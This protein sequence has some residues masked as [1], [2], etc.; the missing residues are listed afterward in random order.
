MPTRLPY[1]VSFIKPGV[2]S[3]IYTFTSGDTTPDVSLGTVFFTATSAVT[4]TNFDGGERGKIIIVTSESNG[5]TTLQNSAGGINLFATIAAISSGGTRPLTYSSS[6]NY[7]MQN[8]DTLMFIHNGTD[9][10]QI[11]PSVRVN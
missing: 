5:V 6:G 4:I 10:S 11:S 7:L 8:K 2:P 3:G 1:G 9:W